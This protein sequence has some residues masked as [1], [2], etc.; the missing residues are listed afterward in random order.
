[1]GTIDNEATYKKVNYSYYLLERVVTDMNVKAYVKRGLAI[2]LELVV[3]FRPVRDLESVKIS[4]LI[5]FQRATGQSEN[6]TRSHHKLHPGWCVFWKTNIEMHNRDF[7]NEINKTKKRS[8]Q[9]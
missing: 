4:S 8:S 3:L 2:F 7:E 6:V 9:S 1:M 5:L